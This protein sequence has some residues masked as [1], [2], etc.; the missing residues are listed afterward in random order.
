MVEDQCPAI[1][2]IVWEFYANFHQRH[3]NSF[4]TWLRGTTIEVTPT[5]ISTITGVPCVRDPTYPWPVDHLLTHVDMVACC[6]KG[7][8]HQMELD[9]EGSFQMSDFSNDVQCIYHILAI[10]VLP[11]ISHTLITI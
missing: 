6:T 7:R 9:G 5:L 1:E 3:G 4:R 10:W 2:E 8:P 11:V